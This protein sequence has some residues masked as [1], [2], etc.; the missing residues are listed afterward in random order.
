MSSRITQIKFCALCETTLDQG[1]DNGWLW[2]PKCR[3][4]FWHNPK[5][6]NW[7]CLTTFEVVAFYLSGSYAKLG[8]TAGEKEFSRW[9]VKQSGEIIKSGYSQLPELMED[10]GK[11]TP[12][13]D[14]DDLETKI[15][16]AL[17]R[18]FLMIKSHKETKS[19]YPP[20]PRYCLVWFP[21]ASW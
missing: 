5:E 11:N 12:E 6:K 17:F 1:W 9:M 2:C 8:Y 18:Y 21:V 3:V 10:Y 16:H 7:C 14:M 4:F 15:S 13:D 20:T 19:T